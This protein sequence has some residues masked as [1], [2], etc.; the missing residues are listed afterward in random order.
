MIST[1]LCVLPKH[2][3]SVEVSIFGIVK[4]IHLPT[5]CLEHFQCQAICLSSLEYIFLLL[6]ELMGQS[7]SFKKLK[8]GL[9][10]SLRET[11]LLLFKKLIKLNSNSFLYVF[12][13]PL[14]IL[15]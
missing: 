3:F 5:I 2:Y 9:L 13:I 12:S 14:S 6:G 10:V 8:S 15:D 7:G 11:F 1:F 4:K